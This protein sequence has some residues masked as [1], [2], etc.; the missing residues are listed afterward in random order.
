[1][2][3]KINNLIIKIRLFKTQIINKYLL[4]EDEKILK[5]LFN[6]KNNEKLNT[7]EVIIF[8]E[9]KNYELVRILKNILLISSFSEVDI[10]IAFYI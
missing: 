8:N 9:K 10:K 6:S 4:K 5:S 3:I 1:M 2:I 7:K